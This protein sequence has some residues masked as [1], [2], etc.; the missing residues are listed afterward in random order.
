MKH[1]HIGV[2]LLLH[3][4]HKASHTS[5]TRTRSARE[6]DAASSHAA[7]QPTGRTS[8][9]ALVRSSSATA[10][11]SWSP[12]HGRT[13]EN[14]GTLLSAIFQNRASRC[15]RRAMEYELF[16]CVPVA[17][18]LQRRKSDV[19]ELQDEHLQVR[20]PEGKALLPAANRQSRASRTQASAGGAGASGTDSKTWSVS[21]RDAVEATINLMEESLSHRRSETRR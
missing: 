1:Y 13:D 19:F 10:R 20:P 16:N 4:H 9:S 12:Q 2:R 15:R 18:K 6:R 5:T 17:R 3:H 8:A 21:V 11:V 7:R 14:P